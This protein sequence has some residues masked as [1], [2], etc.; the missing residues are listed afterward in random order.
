MQVDF[1]SDAMRSL[2]QAPRGRRCLRGPFCYEWI[3]RVGLDTRQWLID[4]SEKPVNISLLR[5]GDK[6]GT[7]RDLLRYT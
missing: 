4:S 2:T 7:L 6:W 3:D 1:D 5:R